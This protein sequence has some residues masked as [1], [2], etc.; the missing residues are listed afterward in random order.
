MDKEELYKEAVELWGEHLQVNM[1]AEEAS[2]VIKAILKSYRTE[3]HTNE[4]FSFTPKLIEELADLAIMLEQAHVLLEHHYYRKFG[5]MKPMEELF[6]EKKQ[7]KLE[8]LEQMIK[9][10]KMKI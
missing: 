9:E 3:K 6:Q 10:S 5:D 7:E 4:S 8:R 1:I 2:E